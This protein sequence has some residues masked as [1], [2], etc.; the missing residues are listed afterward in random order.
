M[1]TEYGDTKRYLL[2][3]LQAAVA[4]TH[5]GD[6]RI[7]Q[8]HGGMGDEQRQEVQRAFNG[9]P[10]HHPVRILVATDAAREGINLQGHCADLMHF[11]VPWNPA[12]MEQRNGRIDRTLQPADVVQCHYFTYIQRREDPVLATLADKV[13]VIGRELGSLGHV[14]MDRLEQDLEE[15]GIDGTS[16]GRVDAALSKCTGGAGAATSAAEL[17]QAR[18]TQRKV[19]QEIEEASTLLQASR[20]VLE[21]DSAL[22]RDALDVG[23]E[24]A[25]AKPLQTVAQ[26]ADGKSGDPVPAFR[27]PELGAGWQTTLDHLR[28]PRHRDEAPW[29]WRKRSPRP[30]TFEPPATLADESI[31]LHLSH[32]LV[33]R[34][35]GR[36]LAQGYS[37]HDL[38]RVTVLQNRND[39]LVR[40]IAFGRLSLFG[41]GATRLHDEV[42]SVAARWVE[43]QPLRP[44]AEEGDKRAITLLEKTLAEAP[45][46]ERIPK[47]VQARVTEAAADLFGQLW[48]SLREEADARAV[49]SEEQLKARGR[50]EADALAAL[51]DRQRDAIERRIGEAEE[52]QLS[53]TTGEREQQ[54]QLEADLKHMQG[55]LASLAR[56]RDTEP[57]DIEGLYTVALKRLSPVGLVVLW[58]KERS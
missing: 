37:S 52:Q 2:Q 31:H 44:F 9:D 19:K 21:F 43:G 47:R 15:H 50:G 53:F 30:V 23:F 12:R 41:R 10:A 35:L 33:Q 36:F 7:A 6:E 17:E 39:S 46:L 4:G 22:L 32:P 29:E 54:R 13:Q 24:L 27:V 28:P 14:V 38:S 34:V 20:K 5:L 18:S 57:G 55:R 45:R 16:S 51:L 3:V 42:L 49:A 25:G 40:V 56:E 48:S 11:D 1:F 8:L 26:N 58:P